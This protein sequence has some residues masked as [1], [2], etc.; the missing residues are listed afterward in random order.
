M[1][2]LFILVTFKDNI[3]KGKVSEL[4]DSCHTLCMHCEKYK[5]ITSE[6]SQ[7]FL[8][9][10]GWA[11]LI[12]L[13]SARTNKQVTRFSTLQDGLVE[14]WNKCLQERSFCTPPNVKVIDF[15]TLFGK[16]RHRT[17]LF[18]KIYRDPDD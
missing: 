10:K 8:S 7:V 14:C 16:L 17:F 3:P 6:N 4:G 2:Q 15:N 18:N 9:K 5:R 11:Y 1:T 13:A 12:E